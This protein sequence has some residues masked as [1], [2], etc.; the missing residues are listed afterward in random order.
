[1]DI[2]ESDKATYTATVRAQ[3]RTPT[4]TLVSGVSCQRPMMSFTTLPSGNHFINLS[5]L[6]VVSDTSSNQTQHVAHIPTTC[7]VEEN[8]HTMRDH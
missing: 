1:M 3:S 8:L 5:R 4:G 2:E 6:S 7:E